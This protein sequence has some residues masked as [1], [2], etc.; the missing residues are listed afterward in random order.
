VG[1]SGCGPC[2]A[3]RHAYEGQQGGQQGHGGGDGE[4]HG[5][6]G[7]YGDAVEE[8]QP[9]DQHAEQRDANGGT[10]EDDRPSRGRD[11]VGGGLG[12]GQPAFQP[13]PVPGDDEQRVVD[14]DAEPD[15]HAQHGCEV[16][17]GHGVPEQHDLGEVPA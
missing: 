6:A 3:R 17:D 2:S 8:T 14:A 15:E 1:T 7:R 9:E 4:D 16:R 11:G 10:R 13:A 12:D 5:E